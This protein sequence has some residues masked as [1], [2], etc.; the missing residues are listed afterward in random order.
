MSRTA[1]LPGH[2][3]LARFA[4]AAAA[5]NRQALG[6]VP[7]D[8]EDGVYDELSPQAQQ[9][10]LPLPPTEAPGGGQLRP[11]AYDELLDAR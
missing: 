4:T 7:E 10:D 3:N 9:S 11:L 8:E 6:H 1:P 5:H 2:I